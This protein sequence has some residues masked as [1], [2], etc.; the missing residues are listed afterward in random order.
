[1]RKLFAYSCELADRECWVKRN[2]GADPGKILA[3]PSIHPMGSIIAAYSFEVEAFDFFARPRGFAEK[4]QA[5]LDAWIRD[6][7]VDPDLS[8]K[9]V[10]SVFFQEKFE[11]ELQR[12]P[13]QRIVRLRM[14]CSLVYLWFTHDRIVSS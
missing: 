3:Y 14:F 7:T 5:R 6:E 12:L 10:P 13:M 4:S 8:G 9:P 1:M 11:Y 2:A